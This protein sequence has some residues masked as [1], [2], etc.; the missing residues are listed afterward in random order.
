MIALLFTLTGVFIAL[1]ITGKPLDITAFM[2]ML[3]VLSIVINNNVLIYNS[4][5]IH[6]SVDEK[7][8]IIDAIAMRI[9]PV[10]MTMFSNAF[11]LLPVALAIGSGTQIIQDLAI[12]IMGG[13]FFAIVVNLYIMPLFFYFIQKRGEK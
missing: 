8:R 5:Q 6:T 11:A 4:Y 1:K 13:L 12:A 7:E 2:G 9:R 3:I 10:L